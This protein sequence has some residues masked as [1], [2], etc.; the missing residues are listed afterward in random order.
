M[1]PPTA[2]SRVSATVSMLDSL[3]TIT[4]TN[5][6]ELTIHEPNLPLER[7]ANLFEL[8]VFCRGRLKN[9]V[10][11][12]LESLLSPYINDEEGG[13]AVISSISDHLVVCICTPIMQRI[14]R[15]VPESRS[16]IHL[17]IFCHPDKKTKLFLFTTWIQIGEVPLGVII[18]DT[19]AHEVFTTGLQLL[20]SILPTG[21]FF[22]VGYP[23]L[24][25]MPDDDT[26][27]RDAF[28]Q[29]FPHSLVLTSK[30]FQQKRFQDFL[31]NPK[32]DIPKPS[33]SDLFKKFKVMLNS[34]TD[35]DFVSNFEKAS[36]LLKPGPAGEEE[37]L[38]SITST[39]PQLELSQLMNL[40]WTE[41]NGF[42]NVF[43]PGL[44]ATPLENPAS[45]GVQILSHLILTELFE[46]VKS[47]NLVQLSQFIISSFELFLRNRLT[48]PLY[49]ESLLKIFLPTK[50]PTNLQKL[51]KLEESFFE[52]PSEGG[53]ELVEMSLLHCT[54]RSARICPHQ[55]AVIHKY[56]TATIP[57]PFHL[58]GFYVDLAGG[59]EVCG[60]QVKKQP[61]HLLPKTNRA[62]FASNH[63][64]K[65]K[66]GTLEEGE[67]LIGEVTQWLT[68]HLN[69]NPAK[70]L[71]ALK[72][73]VRAMDSI[74]S[75]HEAVS[76]AAGFGSG[77]K[78]IRVRS[79]L[80]CSP[81]PLIL[82]PPPP[83]VPT[84][85]VSF[86]T[87]LGTEAEEILGGIPHA[88]YLPLQ[89]IPGQDGAPGYFI[90]VTDDKGMFSGQEEEQPEIVQA[91]SLESAPTEAPLP[92]SVVKRKPIKKGKP[93]KTLIGI[94]MFWLFIL[95]Y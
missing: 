54:C 70:F 56:Y 86:I 9:S 49:V 84:Q 10:Q 30:Y 50:G 27:R 25:V 93:L 14:H 35:E 44:F 79:E 76:A 78:P 61:V 43:R 67:A 23:E 53:V 12:E 15:L 87:T 59:K 4:G 32:N 90:L 73:M 1:T 58:Q 55:S 57:Y 38:S 37:E 94:W 29:E 63:D 60:S 68:G 95:N 21:S 88:T 41:S 3:D 18:T 75:D 22:G 83:L 77:Y 69:Q 39:L 72:S 8:T 6:S 42:A 5:K 64:H 82:P 11:S 20:K 62:P 47:F 7:V 51:K 34:A 91:R 45:E 81:P 31:L 33:H 48:G 36:S 26:R 46:R 17:Q 40:F 85:E 13:R 19:E 71:P 52:V 92:I 16:I 89:E 2:H 24:F 66:D 80:N 28:T 74:G 65:T